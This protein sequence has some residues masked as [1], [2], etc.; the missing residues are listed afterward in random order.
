MASVVVWKLPE[1]QWMSDN[2]EWEEH[3]FDSENAAI[4]SACDMEANKDNPE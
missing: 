4:Q 3:L 1:E 2:H